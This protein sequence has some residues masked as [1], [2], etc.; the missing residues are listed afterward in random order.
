MESYKPNSFKYKEE[1]KAAEKE[2]LQKVTTG[3]VK[4]VKQNGLKKFVNNF[5]ND[6]VPKVKDYVIKDVLVP[7]VKKA[8]SDIVRNGIDMFLYGADAGRTKGK[9]TASKVSYGGFYESPRP[10]GSG[11]YSSRTYTDFEDIEFEKRGDAEYVLE[12]MEDLI[13][14]YKI[15]KI[16]DFYDLAGVSTSN[17]QLCNYGWTD[18]RAAYVQRTPRGYII[19]FPKAMPLD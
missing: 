7:A 4:T 13:D 11:R 17:Y 19:Q 6:D 18:L 1:Q 10:S 2:K 16:S 9:T 14:R 15:V 12:M 3:Q 8:I 5:V